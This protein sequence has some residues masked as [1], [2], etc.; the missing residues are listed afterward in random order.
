VKDPQ[1]QSRFQVRFDWGI[2][3]ARRIASDAHVLV[4]ADAL[5]STEASDPLT[6]PGCAVLAGT[7]GSAAA[8]AQWI[9]ALQTQLG[10]RAIVAVVAAGGP[11][12]AFA[13]EDFL[14]AGAAIDALATLGIDSTSPEAAA[15]S[16]AFEGLRRAVVHLSS[17]SVA[18]QSLD[19]AT[20]AAAAEANAL[21]DVRVLREWTAP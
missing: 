19:S 13:V 6:H 11:S 18:G 5:P 21:P 2:D 3:G 15:A 8:V 9:L 1:S 7:T 10:D 20:L 12:G 16:A 14:A 17:A 4:W